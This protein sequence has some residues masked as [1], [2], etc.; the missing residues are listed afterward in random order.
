MKSAL[1]VLALAACNNEVGNGPLAGSWGADF[2]AGPAAYHL[3]YVLQTSGADS[4][5]YTG[6]AACTGTLSWTGGSWSATANILTLGGTPVCS[7]GPITCTS[8]GNTVTAGTCS[9]SPI[10]AAGTFTYTL[11]SDE[12][13]LTLTAMADGGATFPITLTRE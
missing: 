8:M 11:S 5:S 6:E 13:T 1:I 12:N 9:N 7:G 3:T 4:A 2:T 10:L